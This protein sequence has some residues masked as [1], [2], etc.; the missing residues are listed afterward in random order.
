MNKYLIY[1]LVGV[2]FVSCGGNDEKEMHTYKLHKNIVATMFWVDKPSSSDNS[3][4]S[5]DASAWDDE[6][7]KDYY[8]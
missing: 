7:Q 6:W 5:N 2:I 1:F 4:I 8:N 3:Y